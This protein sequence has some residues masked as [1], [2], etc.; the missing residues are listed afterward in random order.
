[1][2]ISWQLKSVLV[3]VSKM[4][5]HTHTHTQAHTCRATS[6]RTDRSKLKCTPCFLSDPCHP[7]C[8]YN[9]TLSLD[10]LW[11]L[12]K[13]NIISSGLSIWNIV[14]PW[15]IFILFDS[16]LHCFTTRQKWIFCSYDPRFEK[17]D[18]IFFLFVTV[19]HFLLFFN[20]ITYL[21]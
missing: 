14:V 15:Y 11:E 17:E 8:R 1:M 2:K 5:P 9:Y 21:S 18:M 20:L 4:K 6:V 16:I 10:L 3:A 7:Q 19:I 12:N 13:N